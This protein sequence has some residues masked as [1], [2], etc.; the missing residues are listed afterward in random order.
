MPTAIL[1]T[2]RTIHQKCA[3][4]DGVVVAMEDNAKL[5]NVY[6]EVSK[7]VATLVSLVSLF[8]KIDEDS[9]ATY[10][11]KILWFNTQ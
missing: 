7:P 8:N 5:A 9:H 10:S 6:A 4:T 2:L 3:T 11:H 1:E